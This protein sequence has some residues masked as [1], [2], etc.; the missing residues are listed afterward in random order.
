MTHGYKGVYRLGLAQNYTHFDQVRFYDENDGFETRQLINVF[1]INKELVFC[2]GRGIYR[3]N[4]KTD[5][6]VKHEVFSRL[7]GAEI[8]VR[9]MEE[10]ALGN[11]YF[12]AS[13][14]TGLLRKDNFGNYHLEKNV[15]NKIHNQLNDDLEDISVLDYNNIL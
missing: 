4:A 14:Y 10:D 9:K 1:R 11:I 6:F 15:F 5:S 3:Y 8:H 7:L 12:I 13:E 2:S